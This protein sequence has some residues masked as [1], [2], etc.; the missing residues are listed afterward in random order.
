MFCRRFWPRHS[1]G[2]SLRGG[3]KKRL[4]RN[5][6]PQ[7]GVFGGRAASCEGSEEHTI[8]QACILGRPAQFTSWARSSWN[9]VRAVRSSKLTRRAFWADPI[10]SPP[11]GKILNSFF[12]SNQLV[13]PHIDQYNCLRISLMEIYH[14]Q[15]KIWSIKRSSPTMPRTVVF[16]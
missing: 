12:V 13:R 7:N 4:G 11:K 14:I 2:E 9:L 5:S 15:L 8:D 10:G 16:M 3:E 1:E 6:S